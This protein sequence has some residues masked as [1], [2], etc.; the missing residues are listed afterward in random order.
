L[1]YILYRFY[2]CKSNVFCL[3]RIDFIGNKVENLFWTLMNAENT[4]FFSLNQRKSA[5]F[6]VP[7]LLPIESIKSV[8]RKFEECGSR[9][10]ASA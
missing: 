2:R 5:F 10:G 6:C 8:D 3:K 9:I 7:F 4:D 1:M